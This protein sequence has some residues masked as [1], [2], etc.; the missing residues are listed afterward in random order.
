MLPKL[1]IRHIISISI[2]LSLVSCATK[3]QGGAGIGAATGAMFGAILGEKS[4]NAFMGATIGTIFGGIAGSAIGRKLDENDKKLM[5]NATEEALE[6]T[7]S[8]Q[9]I[10]WRNPDSGNEGYI[11]PVKT[12]RVKESYCREFIQEAIVGGEK[13][14]VYGKACRKPDGQW[15]IISTD[16][17]RWESEYFNSKKY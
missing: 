11:K 5:N 13:V 14:K 8:G 2:I 15:K 10:A 17:D 7:K 1:V 9:K 3:E 4:G 16:N 6:N 12:Y